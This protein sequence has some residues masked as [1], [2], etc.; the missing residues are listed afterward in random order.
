MLNVRLVIQFARRLVFRIAQ[1][2]VRV[3]HSLIVKIYYLLSYFHL[4][5]VEIFGGVVSSI[6]IGQIGVLISAP[7]G[8]SLPGPLLLIADRETVNF[9]TP[10]R[11]ISIL[12]LSSWILGSFI[13]PL[14]L[15]VLVPPNFIL[16]QIITGFVVQP[17]VFGNVLD[18]QFLDFVRITI[19][20][21]ALPGFLVI[22]P[23]VKNWL[24]VILIENIKC[25]RLIEPRSTVASPPLH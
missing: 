2:L 10:P 16:L 25:L 12:V 18:H 23:M 22:Y 4:F 11:L 5:L 19:N 3:P 8:L 24:R 15:I 20:L 1:F 14:V 7:V 21:P 13:Y 9:L 17:V 6:A